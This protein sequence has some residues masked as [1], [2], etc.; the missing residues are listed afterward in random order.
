MTSKGGTFVVAAGTYDRILC[1]WL[2]QPESGDVKDR[3]LVNDHAGPVT[4]IAAC[5]KF[6]IT[7]GE[8]ENMRIY[9]GQKLKAVGSLIQHTDTVTCMRFAGNKLLASGAR[10]GR[11]IVYNNPGWVP[12]EL[13]G[14]I[15][16]VND[17]QVHPDKKFLLSVGMDKFM[18][19][20]NIAGSRTVDSR[21]FSEAPSHCVYS[22]K[23][24]TYCISLSKSLLVYDAQ[25]SSEKALMEYKSADIIHCVRYVS[26]SVIAIGCDNKEIR[27]VSV[28]DGSVICA[29]AEHLNRVKS[30]CVHSGFPNQFMASVD[31]N[32]RL[33]LWQLEAS[34]LDATK[35]KKRGRENDDAPAEPA[36]KV[37]KTVQIQWQR[38]LK[39]TFENYP[40][41]V[42]QL[43]E[44]AHMKGVKRFSLPDTSKGTFVLDFQKMTQTN[45]TSKPPR[46][47]TIKRCEGARS[48]DRGDDVT[49][50]NDEGRAIDDKPL[51]LVGTRK[52][53]LRY[54]CVDMW[55]LLDK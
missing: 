5:T 14:H 23:G 17:L 41:D 15:G 24:I 28:D 45:T 4:S 29:A 11:I 46:V 36:K 6:L 53:D 42:S 12:T 20:T 31:S 3:F 33:C 13:K 55:Q 52:T 1:G 9:S 48:T 30:I 40:E 47:R 51:R 27:L 19:V 8:D 21:K 43:I 18:R 54:T 38:D 26:E 49:R 32:G 25:A 50:P 22:P 35:K 34:L 39:G 16:A 10:N 37:A 7:G 44:K 2:W